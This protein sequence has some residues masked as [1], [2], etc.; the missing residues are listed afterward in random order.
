MGQPDGKPELKTGGSN[1]PLNAAMENMKR[2]AYM[3]G[4]FWRYH[5][6]PET[7]R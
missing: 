4:A 1:R 2:P 6:T 3:R 5:L 7:E